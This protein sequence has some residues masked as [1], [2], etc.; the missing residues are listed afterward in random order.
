MKRI[1]LLAAIGTTATVPLSGAPLK[2]AVITKV[3]EDVKI[4]EN[5]RAATS[6]S[7]GQ[8]IGG[9]STVLTG[10]QSRAELSFPDQTVTRI[11]ANSVFRFNSGSRDMSIEKGSFLLQVPKNAGGATIRTA[12]IT[13]AITGTTTLMEY[14]PDQWV[15]FICLEGEAQLS[16][17]YGNKTTISPGSMLIMHPDAREFPRPVTVN[18]TKL[19]KTSKLTNAAVFGQLNDAAVGK[20]NQSIGNQMQRRRGGGLVPSGVIVRGPRVRGDGGPEGGAGGGT[21]GPSGG[22]GPRA[23]PSARVVVA[24]AAKCLPTVARDPREAAERSP[25]EVRRKSP[26]AEIL[27]ALPVSILRLAVDRTRNQGQ[28]VA[29]PLRQLSY[30]HASH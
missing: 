25:A 10:R 6:A 11:G 23:I 27:P 19:V 2:S 3:V 21:G 8:K 18:L 22:G 17:K 20:I 15:K 16:N 1:L 4:S 30:F 28:S 26:E 14:S 5:S 9:S 13:A 7:T 29:P 24:L 12:T